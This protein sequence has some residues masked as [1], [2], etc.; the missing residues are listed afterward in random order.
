GEGKLIREGIMTAIIGRPNVGKSSLLN[1]L[2]HENRAIVT[3]VP[4]TTRDVIEEY[5]TMGGIPLK[6]LDTAGIRETVDVV[7]RMGVE[8]SRIALAE[9]DLIL[10]MFSSSDMLHL[11]EMKLM[12]ELKDRNTL[13][14]L[15]KTDLP[16]KLDIVEVRRL[17]TDNRIVRMSIYEEK[18]LD[19]L[20]K[21]IRELFFS[22]DIEGGDFT[23]VSNVRHIRLMQQAEAAL[24]DALSAADSFIPIDLI[25]IDIRLAWEFLGEIIGETAAESLVDQIFTQFCLGK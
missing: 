5:V 4:G 19:D 18:G 14:I 15:N 17:F 20:E 22:G 10:L 25:Q 9:A 24:N 1:A 12:E 6:L 13:I 7:E 11:D 21:A 23:Y 2:A 8:R 3:D 16:E